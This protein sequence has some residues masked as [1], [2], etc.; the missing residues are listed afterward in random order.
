MRDF[1]DA[2][3]MAQ[4]LRDEL[5]AKGVSLTHSDNL[6]VVAK[7][8]GFHDWNTLAAKIQSENPSLIT[9][10]GTTIPV[11]GENVSALVPGYFLHIPDAGAVPRG[12]RAT[13]KPTVPTGAGL[14]TV[15]LRDTV[16]F[17]NTVIPLFVGRDATKRALGDTMAGDKRILAVTQ[18][19]AADD[20]PTPDALYNV[21]IIASVIDLV[22]LG[23]GT[24]K[25][26]VKAV[27]RAAIIHFAEG[28]FLT[29]DTAPIQESRG[30]EEEAFNLSRA[31][32]EKLQAHRNIDF[33]SWP[34][35]YLSRIQEPS[36]L[37]DAIAPLLSAEIDKKQELL[38]TSDVVTRLEKI[39]ALMNTARQ[40]A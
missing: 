9:Q 15:P 38:E 14:P 3:A 11:A 19:R 16:L 40:P 20:A 13:A 21:G 17:P 4:T 22:S 5:K 7:I 10:P 8:L 24:M 39:L 36:V 28:E 1:R 33:L 6:E 12:R 31:M 29:A 25:L 2:K 32:L 18:R 37:A 35:A 27:E 34:Y 30:A 23:D 26:V